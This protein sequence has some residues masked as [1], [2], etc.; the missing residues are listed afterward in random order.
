[1][2]FM[3][4]GTE[5]PT[6]GKGSKLS[7]K[8]ALFVDEYLVDLNGSA[9]VLRAGYKTR[10]QNRIASDLLNHPLVKAEIEAR[11]SQRREK[12]ELKADYLINKLIA[13]IEKDD[14]KDGDVIRAI[15]LAGKSIALWKE[16]QEISG[17]DG[18]SIKMEQ[19]VQENVQDFTSKL[20]RLASRG[21]SG[22]VVK[23]VD[24][25]RKS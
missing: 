3:K 11:T 12:M 18:E 20:S 5:V 6:S 9:A 15:E 16:R 24:G 19:K 23:L 21:G 17:P 1:M 13:M 22:D 10:N 4:A 7:P 25:S 2:P 14:T 8:M